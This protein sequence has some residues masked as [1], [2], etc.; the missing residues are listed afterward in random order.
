MKRHRDGLRCEKNS[1]KY[2][3]C[4]HAD[5]YQEEKQIKGSDPICSS[6]VRNRVDLKMNQS[7]MLFPLIMLLYEKI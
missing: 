1:G 6:A 5:N 4:G 2:A 7:S 3:W